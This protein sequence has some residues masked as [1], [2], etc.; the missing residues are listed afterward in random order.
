[1]GFKGAARSAEETNGLLA[2]EG[3]LARRFTA[4]A[5]ADCIRF[6]VGRKQEMD[7]VVRNLEE[8]LNG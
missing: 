3:I 4:A 1:M 2:A 7:R 8:S 5:F 6:T